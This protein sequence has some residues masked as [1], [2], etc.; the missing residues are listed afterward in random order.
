MKIALGVEYDG[1]AFSGWEIQKDRQTV[2]GVVERALSKVADQPL[3]TIC[4][5]RT[6]AG[7]HAWGQVVHFNTVRSR[8]LRAWVFGTNTGL[9]SSVSVSWAREVAEDFHARFS[10]TRRC[11]RYLMLNR[12]ARSGILDRRVGWESRRLDVDLMH[13]AAQRLLG[14]HDFSAFRAA[15]CQASS[16]RRTIYQLDVRREEDL[17]VVDIVANAFLQHMVRNLVGSLLQVG[18]GKYP[19][20]WIE[21]LLA[22][23]DRTQGGPTVTPYGLYLVCVEY[24]VHYALPVIAPPVVPNV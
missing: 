1:R 22:S 21:N 8:P 14:E 16:P 7:V 11:Y 13:N 9:P 20:T 4:A 5:G 15:Q 24:P 6:D 12:P 3:R 10:A 17:I 19:P 2:Q 18:L 23:R